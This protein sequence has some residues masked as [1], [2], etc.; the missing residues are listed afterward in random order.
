[1]KLSIC[2]MI[3]NEEKNLH[4]CLE[5][6]KPLTELGLAELIIVDTGSDDKSVIIAK[7][8]TDRVYFHKWNKNFSE[9]RNISISYAKGEWIFI[10]DADERLDDTEKLIQLMNSDILSKYNSVTIKV[11]NLYDIDNEKKYNLIESPR[12][13]KN[14]VNFRYEGAVHNQPIF[15]NPILNSD[16]SLTHFGY[17]TNDKELMDKKFNRTVELLEQELAK[18]PNNIYY[19]YQLGISYDMH[20]ERENALIQMKKAYSI[21]REKSELEKRQYVY[22]YSAY[23]RIAYNNAKFREALNISKEGLIIEKDYIDFYYIAGMAENQLKNEEKSTSFFESY[24][25]LYKKFNNLEISKDLTI[26]MYHI[27]DDAKSNVCFNLFKYYFNNKDYNKAYVVYKDIINVAE[28]I[29]SSINILSHME[30]YS[31][32]RDVYDKIELEKDKNIFLN[33]LENKIKEVEDNKK[34]EFYKEFSLIENIYGKFNKIRISNNLDQKIELTKVLIEEI[35]FNKQPTFYSEIFENVKDNIKLIIDVLKKLQVS[36]IKNIII[37]LVEQKKFIE[38]FEKY[39]LENNK[40]VENIKEIKM[41]IIIA[42]VLML[43]NLNDNNKVTQK[44]LN[45]FKIYLNEGI[46]FIQKL[47]KVE[48]AEEIYECI[49]DSEER[50]F[51]IMYIFNKLIQESDKKAAIKYMIEAV[52]TY[53]AFS[54]YIDIYKDEI[55]NLNEQKVE[56]EKNKEFENYKIK[57]KENIKNLINQG[58][59]EEA[60]KIISEYEGIVNRD[61][62]IYSMKAIIFIMENKIQDAKFILESGLEIDSNNFDLAYNLAYLYEQIGEFSEAIEFYIKAEETCNNDNLKED[63]SRIIDKI[64]EEHPNIVFIDKKNEFENYKIKVKQ[65]IT[66]LINQGYLEESK[67]LIN[68]YEKIVGRDLDICSMKSVICIMEN[69]FENAESILKE[70]LEI[71][72]NNFDLNYNLAYVYYNKNQYELSLMYYIKSFINTKN[73]EIIKNIKELIGKLL[74]ELNIDEDVEEFLENNLKENEK[75]IIQKCLILCHF[76]SVYTKEFLEKIYSKTNI[77]F[78]VLTL[79]NTYKEKVESGVI[80]NVYTYSDLN[81]MNEILNSNDKYDIIH[82]HFLTPFYGEV[83]EQIRNKCTKLIITIWGS[84]FYRTTNEQKEQQRKLVEKADI[85]TFDNDVTMDDFAKYYNII[86]KEKLSI[87]RFGL[88]A[89]E[90]IKDLEDVECDQIKEEYNIPQDSIVVTCGY[91]ANPAHNHLE[92]I[93]SIKQIKNN[94]P[95]NMCYIFP[96]TYQRDEKYCDIVK[97]ELEKSG[98]KYIILEKFMEFEEIAKLT[99]ITDIMIQVQTTDTLSATMQEHMYNGNIIITGSWLPYKPLKEVGAYFLEVFS[100]DKIGEKLTEV[101]KDFSMLKQNCLKNKNI[102]WNFSAWENTV[103][104][105]KKVYCEKNEI[106]ISRNMPLVSICIPVYNCEDYIYEAIKSAI[107]QTYQNIEIIISDNCSNDRTAEI[108]NSIKDDRIRYYRHEKPTDVFVDNWNYSAE[109]ANGKYIKYLFSDDILNKECVAMLVDIMEKDED[110]VI[111]SGDFSYIN[112]KGEITLPYVLKGK[113]LFTGKYL[114]KGILKKSIIRN[115]LIGCPSNVM[116]RKDSFDKIK[117]FSTRYSYCSDDYLYYKLFELGSYYFVNVELTK[118]R[119]YLNL[120]KGVETTSVYERVEEFYMMLEEFLNNDLF[121]EEEIR[122]AYYNAMNGSLY[123]FSINKD[124]VEKIKII[125]KIINYTKF[126]DKETLGKL[127]SIREKLI[128][129]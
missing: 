37:Y 1:M 67:N 126:L 32:L 125:N 75:S 105:W 111:A 104:S 41:F 51:M 50:F 20:K 90:Y 83:A 77:E 4:R 72:E 17:I 64:K 107:D 38:I 129:G 116:I 117:G 63:I 65:N 48:N 82:V 114:G 71:D 103:E 112:E 89:L 10:I 12:I 34:I 68:E 62:E 84:D 122:Q 70:G 102:I 30:K 49:S 86:N 99:K 78:D 33:T 43:N 5:K 93:K 3:K 26:V 76:Y 23:A 92:I 128:E 27:Y 97:H 31:E 9:M 94:L 16:I 45:I 18:D 56:Q 109:L 58:S 106:G 24:L 36:N 118:F 55:F 35:D 73:N 7:E 42:N 8:Y 123:S 52:N 21:L 110:L 2:M 57:I 29:Y 19:M 47:Y 119:S 91:N 80:K 115:N 59:L 6:L 108:I 61:L 96:M 22:I 127:K 39:V 120:E 98:L 100:V 81:R 60:K 74:I 121:S 101:M 54:K 40:N 88:T 69:K 14:D 95:Q 25:K 85:I 13:F 28:K 15:D 87:N 66:N 124:K 44:Y 53:E 113:Q 11:K 79:E 46:N